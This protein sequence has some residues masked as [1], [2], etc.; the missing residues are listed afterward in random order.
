MCR[1]P[2][3][4]PMPLVT[5]SKTVAGFNLS[6]FADEHDLIDAYMAQIVRWLEQGALTVEAVT[7]LPVEQIGVAHELIQSGQSKGK[8]VIQL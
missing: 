7:V 4:D 5:D 6:F 2:A 3:F 1:M 8:I